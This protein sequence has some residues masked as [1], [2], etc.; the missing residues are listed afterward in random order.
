[1]QRRSMN[2]I[3]AGTMPA[4]M[5]SAT[6]W[7]ASGTESNAASKV[8]VTGGLGS[9]R[10]V[11]STTTPSSPSEPATMPSRSKPRAPGALP[12]S[13]DALAA[14]QRDLDAQ[15]IVRG[16]AVFQ[17]VQPAGIFR[18]IAADGAGDLARR[19]GRVVEAVRLRPRG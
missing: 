10:S 4:A 13:D 14:S 15:Q 8:R 9:N 5:M 3:A 18:D 19:I 11:A 16:Q 7:P 2:S 17:T 6:H 12:P 1:M